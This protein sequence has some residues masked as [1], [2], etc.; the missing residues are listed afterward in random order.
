MNELTGWSPVEGGGG[1]EGVAPVR[2]RVVVAAFLEED[3][4]LGW[5]GHCM[6]K[7]YE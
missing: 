4:L 7:D 6:Y 1:G 5:V 3:L 2:R